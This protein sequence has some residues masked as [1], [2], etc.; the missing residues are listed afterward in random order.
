[1]DRAA[2]KSVENKTGMPAYIKDL[3]PSVTALLVETA[4]GDAATL[5]RQVD[6]INAEFESVLMAHDFEFSTD[7]VRAADLWNIRKGLFPSAFIG[8]EKGTTVIMEGCQTL[9]WV[10]RN[11][12]RYVGKA[13]REIF[14]QY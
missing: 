8:R 11:Q 7:P 14:Y 10:I 4:A 2:L 3:G 6:E 1:M 5:K 12:I 9:N 13:E